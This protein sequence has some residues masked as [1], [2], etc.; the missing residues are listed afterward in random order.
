MRFIKMARQICLKVKLL[1][2]KDTIIEI[3]NVLG[4]CPAHIWGHVYFCTLISMSLMF[5]LLLLTALLGIID[6]QRTA[7]V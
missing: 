7:H 2:M 6:I 4:E 1:E 5:S 3:S